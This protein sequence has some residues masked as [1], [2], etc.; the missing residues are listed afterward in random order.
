MAFSCFGRSGSRFANAQDR[1]SCTGGTASNRRIGPGQCCLST[2]TPNEC[3]NTD[4]KCWP[5][6]KGTF[7]SVSNTNNGNG[8]AC[9]VQS[10]SP[11]SDGGYKCTDCQPGRFANQTQ[12]SFCR[13]CEPGRF[14]N[15]TQQSNCLA[16]APGRFNNGS[17]SI[18]C[19]ECS[20]NKIPNQQQ[21]TCENCTAGRFTP[22]PG[23]PTCTACSQ[24]T[25]SVS[26][27][28]CS[29]CPPANFS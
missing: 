2:N 15:L 14:Q 29:P 19:L 16:C 12:S 5:C 11:D 18:A 3:R 7:S 21:T 26:G 24:N 8:A 1:T 22:G 27:G 6:S 13:N 9:T 25:S 28:A 17:G 10:G 23:T 4:L 20:T